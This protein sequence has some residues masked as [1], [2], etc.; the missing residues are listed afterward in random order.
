VKIVNCGALRAGMSARVRFAVGEPRRALLVDKDAVLRGAG[1]M[2]VFVIEAGR[3]V[4]RDVVLGSP[5]GRK[6]EVLDGLRAGEQVIVGGNERLQP[7]AAVRVIEREKRAGEPGPE[8]GPESG[9][10]TGPAGGPAA[11]P[12]GESAGKPAAEPGKEP[13]AGGGGREQDREQD[14]ARGAHGARGDSGGAAAKSPE[15]GPRPVASRSPRSSRG[16]GEEA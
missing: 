11:K 6:L 3:A 7:G 9:P 1:G 15:A 5:H 2:H 14:R 16:E 8:S 13:A 4:R 12:A 10:S